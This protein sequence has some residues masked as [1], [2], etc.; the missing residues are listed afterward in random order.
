MSKKDI[1]FHFFTPETSNSSGKEC[2]N[3]KKKPNMFFIYR[4][5]MMKFR[6]SNIPMKSYSKQVSGWWK[7]LSR[8]NKDELQRRYQINRD[9]KSHN[10]TDQ[11][12]DCSSSTL[13]DESSYDQ[14]LKFL[15]REEIMFFN[16]V[17]YPI[18]RG[19]TN[20]LEVGKSNEPLKLRQDA[21]LTDSPPKDY[22]NNYNDIESID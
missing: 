20:L 1:T 13:T 19:D 14:Y 6:P 9:Q 3:H 18:D 7:K 17:E 22:F 15:T 16:F 8:E 4:S 2:K 5:E 12:G 21:Y 10:G 11:M